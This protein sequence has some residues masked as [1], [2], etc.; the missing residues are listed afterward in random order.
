MIAHVC[1]CCGVCVRMYV[2]VVVCVCACM[3][4]CACMCVY[5]RGGAGGGGCIWF[6][7][8]CGCFHVL[9]VCQSAWCVWE[10]YWWRENI[11]WVYACVCII[12]VCVH[13]FVGVCVYMFVFSFLRVYKSVWCVWHSYWWRENNSFDIFKSL[14]MLF[15][16]VH[17][18]CPTGGDGPKRVLLEEVRE[19]HQLHD[20]V[21]FIGSLNHSQ[22]RE[23]TAAHW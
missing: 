22:V 20:R 6:V 5:G 7:C 19:Q 1:V 23:V 9:H 3:F 12:F 8:M 16:F 13:L 21:T 14:K 17:P 15:F 11:S 2:G 10:I 4:M 18:F